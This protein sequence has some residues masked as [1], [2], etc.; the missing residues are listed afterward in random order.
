M[1]NLTCSDDAK[2]I[3]RKMDDADPIYL[4][5]Y[6]KVLNFFAVYDM[7]ENTDH[8]SIIKTIFGES[9]NRRKN[10]D[11]V[12]IEIFCSSRTLYRYLH[13]YVTCINIFVEEEKA[14]AAERAAHSAIR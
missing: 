11:G 7:V 10:M 3:L 14:L 6:L 5:A 12:A 13:K 2:T 8:A 9:A 1:T 4:A